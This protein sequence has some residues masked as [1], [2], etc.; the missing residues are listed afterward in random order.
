MPEPPSL[1]PPPPP[2]LP[3]AQ[4]PAWRRAAA[5]VQWVTDSGLF[6]LGFLL[7]IVVLGVLAVLSQWSDFTSG[8][9]RLGPMAA[10]EALLCVLAAMVATMLV[11]RSLLG[12]AGSRL[13]LRA[14]ARIFFIGQL[15][16]YVPGSVWPVLTQMELGRI[17]RVPRQRSATAAMLAMLIGLTSSLLAAVIGLPFMARDSARQYWWV[18]LFIP[19]MLVFLHP[20]VLNPVI[21]R[22]L[23]LMRKPVPEQPL[24]ARV[25]VKAVAVNLAVWFFFGLQIWVM[26]ARLGHHGGDALLT[27]V[28]AF[29]LA[30]GVGFVIILAPA[31]AGPRDAILIAT[32]IP[33]VGD[34]ADATAIALVS[35]G[36]TVLADL[37]L[38]GAAV[39]LS[40]GAPLPEDGASP[41]AD[42][43]PEPQ[44]APSTAG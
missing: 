41:F 7:A 44:P 19:V 36:V 18:F 21:A 23:R 28:G 6:K 4:A 16:K 9:G 20:R 5:R 38:G 31:G 2:P 13:S 15:G 1:P 27:G 40:R 12:A 14:A 32:L 8:L 22:G 42:A 34:R 39:L 30:W 35:R 43:D 29:A 11:W 37:I 26:T 24:T 33:L 10:F 25:L 3:P 17:Y